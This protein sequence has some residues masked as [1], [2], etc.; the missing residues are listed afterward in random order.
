[1][2]YTHDSSTSEGLLR[3]LI[4]DTSTAGTPVVG[5]DYVFEDAELTNILDLNSDDLWRAAADCCRRLAA[6]YAKEAI[7]L[8]LG[9]GDIKLDRKKKA[10]YYLDLAK[11][12]DNR[13]GGNVTEY[14][15]SFNI[16]I[17]VSGRDDSEYIGD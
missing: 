15:D 7:D 10:A 8:G 11:N 3:S 6:K 2:A 12:F 14:I 16:D 4:D 13:S 1:M 5:T 9:R 17:D